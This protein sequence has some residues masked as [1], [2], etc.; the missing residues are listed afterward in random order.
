MNEQVGAA[1]P[2]WYSDPGGSGNER[3][4]NG[5]RWTSQLRSISGEA[6]AH[7]GPARR[8]PQWMWV[9]AMSGL[10]IAGAVAA[11]I[12]LPER[13]G[14]RTPAATQ[15][16]EASSGP[17]VL[18]QQHPVSSPATQPACGPSQG[19]A[20]SSALAKYPVDPATGWAWTPRPV[21]SNYQPCAELSAIL[22]TV[23]GATGSSPVQALMF[24]R[25]AFLG[26]GTSQAY[27]FTSLNR[28]AS[29]DDTV[30][31]SYRTGQSC[32]A[33]D[34]GL[35]TNVRYYWDG[36]SVQMLDPAPPS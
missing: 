28:G 27:G 5:E 23:E 13:D 30:V 24:H 9:I 6:S 35:T 17:V 22:V 29:T 18:R 10:I 25:G 21:D 12:W 3:Y 1:S 14:A 8:R 34:D 16:A 7:V 26:T 11:A 2:G 19:T 20:L 4:W 32:T 31:L 36:N 15:E 33:C